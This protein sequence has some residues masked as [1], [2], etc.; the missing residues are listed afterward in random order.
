LAGPLPQA[1]FCPT[2]G[3]TA[4]QAPAYLALDNVLCVGG[5]W[6]TPAEKIN[7]CDWDAITALARRA[8]MLKPVA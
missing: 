8:I 4:A 3:I 1:R 5:S 6:I 2:G 7:A